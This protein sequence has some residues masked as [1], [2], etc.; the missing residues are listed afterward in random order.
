MEISVLIGARTEHEKKQRREEVCQAQNFD[1]LK[2]IAVRHGYTNSWICK[3]CELKR[4]PFGG[5]E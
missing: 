5:Q 2:K 1:E 3:M 4:I